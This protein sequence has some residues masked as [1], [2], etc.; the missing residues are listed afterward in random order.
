MGLRPLSLV[1]RTAPAAEDSKS[2]RARER[3]S[4]R[5][6]EGEPEKWTRWVRG[7]AWHPH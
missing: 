2:K 5:G 3:A 1:D 6:E 7:A 4:E